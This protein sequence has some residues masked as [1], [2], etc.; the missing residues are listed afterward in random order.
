MGAGP[1][2]AAVLGTQEVFF[3]VIAT[4]LTLV[5]VFVPISFLPGQT[6]RLF[7]E[8]GFTLAMCVALSLRRGADPRADA[9]LAPAQGA[10]RSRSTTIRSPRS[11]ACLPASIAGI[12]RFCLDT[13]LVVIV[14]AVL[15]AGSALF[16]FGSHPPGADAARGSRRDHRSA[17]RRRRP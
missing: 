9:R 11:A 14:I 6:G 12:L 1:R 13:P 10:R 5:A 3:A 2:A 8:F 4:S 16:V 7:R 15:F 17:S